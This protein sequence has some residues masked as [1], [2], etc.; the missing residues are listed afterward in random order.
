MLKVESNR[1][2]AKK[3]IIEVG[4]KV[5]IPENNYSKDVEV[6][7]EYIY[8]DTKDKG[9]VE[10]GELTPGKVETK[11]VD[12]YNPETGKI[13]QTT[14]QVVT[15][16]KQKVIVG[17]KDF[18]GK[19]EYSKTCPIPF[20]VEIIEDDTLE[21]GKSEVEQKGIPGSKTTKYER[22]IKNGQAVGEAKKISEET[23]KNPVK[24]IVRVGTK[25]V[26]G[27]VIF[28]T[29]IPFEVEVIEDPNLEAGKTETRQEGEVGKKVTTVTIDNNQEQSRE[30]KI[31]KNPVKKII[32]VGTKKVCEIP[33]VPIVPAEDQSEEPK[34]PE[35]PGEDTPGDESPKDP[36][37]PG[38]ETPGEESPKDSE[39]PGEGDANKPGEEDPTDPDKEDP[40]T[41]GEDT[42]GEE[43]PKEPE[44]EPTKED[45]KPTDA[46]QD[47]I[48]KTG[49]ASTTLVGVLTL[50]SGLGAAVLNKKKED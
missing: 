28:E 23:T 43:E 21:K 41:P 38:E 16:A 49:V 34:D 36:E 19:Y 44:V 11:V 25:P 40:E 18:T 12:K 3:H 20:E 37:T 33:L 10:T 14:E 9:V 26:E 50:V 29:E 45:T 32:A 7:I 30:E 35:T 27:K 1:V 4:T 15:K 5:E 42:P 39:T 2:E 17:T 13:E 46:K 31:E 22:N 24:H 48:A 6:E 47:N 8:D